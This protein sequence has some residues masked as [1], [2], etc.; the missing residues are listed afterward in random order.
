VVLVEG[1]YKR[2]GRGGEAPKSLL[3]D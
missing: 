3:D 1:G 2:E